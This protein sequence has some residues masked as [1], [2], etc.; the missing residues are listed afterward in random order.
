MHSGMSRAVLAGV[1]CAALAA[2]AYA[3]ERA[4]MDCADDFTCFIHAGVTCEPAQVVR[5]IA[6]EGQGVVLMALTRFELRGLQA[7]RC[8]LYERTEQAILRIDPAVVAQLLAAG[9]PEEQISQ[10][11]E[12]LS[13]AYSQMAV[14]VDGTCTLPPAPLASLLEAL[15]SGVDLQFEA[16]SPYCEGPMFTAQ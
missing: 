13:Q 15:N 10:Q 7:E 2:P 1:L 14:G 8:V 12:A 4:P 9:L 11:E 6:A 16:Y 5:T 3:Q